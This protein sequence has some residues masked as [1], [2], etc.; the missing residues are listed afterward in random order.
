V[1]TNPVDQAAAGLEQN[2]ARHDHH[3]DEQ[4]ANPNGRFALGGVSHLRATDTEYRFGVRRGNRTAATRQS[5]PEK[6][7]SPET[8]VKMG[9]IN[10]SFFT[11][12][13]VARRICPYPFL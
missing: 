12:R 8:S 9:S 6:A 5:D 13:L 2:G 11:L 4:N 10:S 7:V 3:R 1:G